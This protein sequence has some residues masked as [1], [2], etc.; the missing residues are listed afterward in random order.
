LKDAGIQFGYELLAEDRSIAAGT[1]DPDE[2]NVLRESILA[3]LKRR[4]D[5]YGAV[6][7]QLASNSRDPGSE[8]SGGIREGRVLPDG[9]VLLPGESDPH[10]DDR[11]F[12]GDRLPDDNRIEIFPAPKSDR[13]GGGE[14]EVQFA[15]DAASSDDNTFNPA[16]RFGSP[17]DTVVADGQDA[18]DELLEGASDDSDS[19]DVLAELKRNQMDAQNALAAA[20]QQLTATSGDIG[21]PADLNRVRANQRMLSGNLGMAFSGTSENVPLNSETSR[22]DVLFGPA[23]S[24]IDPSDGDPSGKTSKEG[25]P[26]SAAAL[27]FPQSPSDRPDSVNQKTDPATRTVGSAEGS[28][29]SGAGTGTAASGAVGNAQ[30]RSNADAESPGWLDQFL[31][32]AGRDSQ[33]PDPWLKKILD[34]AKDNEVARQPITITVE[35][36]RVLVGST[37]PIELSG[38]TSGLLAETLTRLN[39]EVARATEHSLQAKP[40]VAVFDVR[41]G[42]VT[43]YLRLERELREMGITTRSNVSMPPANGQLSSPQQSGDF[44]TGNMAD[45]S[46]AAEESS[47]PDLPPR[48]DRRIA[49]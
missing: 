29:A 4:Q 39:S 28:F 19:S 36:S 6:G 27:Q 5:L 43:T 23:L 40:P 11:F 17:G 8:T 34:R 33:R 12:A 1:A 35:K 38:D 18:F 37:T 45:E 3:A 7:H 44:G 22:V 31:S 14:S 2:M 49:L 24:L 42:G 9:R 47:N 48:L 30:A 10:Q 46:E 41:P 32:Q 15:Q 21:A 16:A 20:M 13:S 26:S 25:P